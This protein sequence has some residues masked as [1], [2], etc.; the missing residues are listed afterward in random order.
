MRSTGIA[1]LAAALWLL[2]GQA[3][4]AQG[5]WGAVISALGSAGDMIASVADGIKKAVDDTTEIVDK[6][7]ARKLRDEVFHLEASISTLTSQKQVLVV[8]RLKQYANPGQ[9]HGPEEWAE[10]KS[11]LSDVAV[12]IASL[13]GEIKKSGDRL[14]RIA[15]PDL[16]NQM[17]TAFARRGNAVM[18]IQQLPEPFSSGHAADFDVLLARYQTLIDKTNELNERLDEYTRKF[19]TAAH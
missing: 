14:V 10:A 3:A 9:A 8:D 18:E 17:E 15:G 1:V 16:L 6:M 11:Q 12:S 4:P 19:G 7:E 13:A 2:S 5:S